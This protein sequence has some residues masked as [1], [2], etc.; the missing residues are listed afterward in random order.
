MELEIETMLRKGATQ[1]VEDSQN[2]F[3]SLML[4]VDSGYRPKHFLCSFQNE[5]SHTFKGDCSHRSLFMQTRPKGFLLSAALNKTS[6]NCG[7]FPW[8]GNLYKFLRRCSLPVTCSKNFYKTDEN[9]NCIYRKFSCSVDNVHGWYLSDGKLIRKNNDVKRRIDFHITESGAFNILSKICFD[10]VSSNSISGGRNRLAQDDSIPSLTKEVAMS[11]YF[12]HFAVPRYFKSIRCYIK[13]N[14]P[15]N[16]P[17]I[18]QCQDLLN[19]SDVIS[20]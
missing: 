8:W 5:S 12:G 15:T 19:K 3:L 18:L 6:R 11:R 2:Q 14:N 10:S 7:R 9:P 20:R 1:M 16:R 4:L 13:A 17:S